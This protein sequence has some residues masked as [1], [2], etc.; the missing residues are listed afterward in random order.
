VNQQVLDD[1]VIDFLDTIWTHYKNMTAFQ[2]SALTHQNGSPWS[3]V[4]Q[5][6]PRR[7]LARNSI[8]IPNEIILHYYETKLSVVAEDHA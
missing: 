4:A 8:I 1:S 6:Y 2:L 5:N 3:Q 7:K